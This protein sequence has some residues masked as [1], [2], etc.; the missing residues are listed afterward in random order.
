MGGNEPV[1]YRNREDMPN[2]KKLIVSGSDAHL[3]SLDIATFISASNFEGGLFKGD[4][5][6]LTNISASYLSNELTAS[7]SGAFNSVSQSIASDIEDIVDGTT[8]VTSASYALTASY[9]LNAG[10]GTGVGFPF[11]GSAIITGSLLVSSSFVDFTNATVISGSIFSGSF[12][13]DG[14]GLT[15]LAGDVDTGSLLTTASAAGSTITFEKGDGSTFDVSI[16]ASASS[17]DA[18]V[19]ASIDGSTLT[20]EKGDASTFDII[21][22]SG[23]NGYSGETATAILSQSTAAETWSFAHNLNERHPVITVYDDNEDVIVPNTISVVDENN[24]DIIFSTTRTGYATAVVVGVS[25]SFA[26]TASYIESLNVDGPLGLD[27]ITSASYA[28]TASYADDFNANNITATSFTGSFSGS[29]YGDGSNLS[30]VTSYTDVDTLEYI[31]SIGVVSSSAQI[32]TGSFSGSFFGDGTGLTGLGYGDTKKLYQ[33]V[34]ATTWSFNHNMVEQYPT[35]TVYNDLNEVVQPTK[36]VAVDSSSLDIYFGIPTA[37]TAVAVV[38]GVATTQEAGYN[39]VL[40]QTLSATTWSFTHNL[41]NKYPQ[42]SVYDSSD[43]LIIPG[44]L[45]AVDQNNLIIYFDNPH[46]GTATATVGGTSLTAS[47]ADSLVISDTLLTYQDNTDVDTGTETIATVSTSTYDGAFFDYI[48]KDGTNFR[49]GTVLSV[50]DGSSIEYTETSTQDIGNTTGVTMS[51]D[52]SGTD[53]RLRATTTSDNW[54]IKAFV[55]AL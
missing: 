34:A 15:G 40:E 35:V 48:I 50:W 7:I 26:T 22:P 55:R 19:T 5:S 27:S 33:T 39:R 18:L 1:T 25:S 53:A 11:S 28:L 2:W 37:G 51:V 45:E 30:G 42:V 31:N 41:G 38:G 54:N 17:A 21:L 29:F 16:A 43:E 46:A 4:G 9:A 14:S 20:F 3:N 24:L 8:T 47:Y 12:V 10:G 36:I 6:Q 49:A 32:N 23:G 13:G 52:I 44:K